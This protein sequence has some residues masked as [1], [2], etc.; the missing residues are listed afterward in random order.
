MTDK[1]KIQEYKKLTALC[2]SQNCLEIN[3]EFFEQQ[4]GTAM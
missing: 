4:E 1:I 2:M 3:N